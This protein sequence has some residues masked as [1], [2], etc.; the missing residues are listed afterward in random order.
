MCSLPPWV[1]VTILG[2][3]G[4]FI[5]PSARCIMTF[6]GNR[7]ARLTIVCLVLGLVLSLA[8]C[9][10]AAPATGGSGVATASPPLP[11]PP[12]L[13]EVA[14]ETLLATEPQPTDSLVAGGGSELQPNVP[15]AAQPV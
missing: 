5:Q 9:G 6:A 3:K 8:G 4:A 12:P 11:P 7:S 15:E 2:L 13:L 1:H 14:A 10:P